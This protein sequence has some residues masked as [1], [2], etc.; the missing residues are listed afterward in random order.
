VASLWRAILIGRQEIIRANRR[1]LAI[2]VLQVGLVVAV[3]V[4]GAAAGRRASPEAVFAGTVVAAI[5]AARVYVLGARVPE[6][7]SPALDASHRVEVAMPS[8]T[9]F[10][11]ALSFSLPAYLSNIVQMANY[12][13]DLFFVAFFAGAAQVGVYAIAVV[14]AQLVWLAPQAVATVLLPSTAADQ[15]DLQGN[16][17]RASLGARVSLWGGLGVGLVL[18]AVSGWVI[19]EVFGRSFAGSSSLL[20]WLLPGVCLFAPATVFASFIAGMGRPKLNLLVSGVGFVAT[21]CL[22]LLLIPVRGAQG[23]AIASSVSYSISAV[24]MA[25]IFLKVSTAGLSDIVLLRAEDVRAVVGAAR[26]A[27]IRGE[28]IA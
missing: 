2:R 13:L 17:E 12:R 4:A 11:R 15:Q 7:T 20:L 24:V 27:M 18:A 8:R 14:L 16:S 5:I 9:A 6:A 21:I 23:A 26:A 19:P 10:R 22:D 28:V 3:V 25:A 1:D